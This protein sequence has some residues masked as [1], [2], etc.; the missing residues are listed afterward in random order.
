[1]TEKMEN[2]ISAR[3]Y[4]IVTASNTT[5]AQLAEIE[6]RL[7]ELRLAREI[8]GNAEEMENKVAAVKQTEEVF[9][10]LQAS[11]KLL[12]ELQRKVKEDAAFKAV[13]QDSSSRIIFG[14]VYSGVQMGTNNGSINLTFGAK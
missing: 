13:S 2:M 9:K 3:H 5:Q 6:K 14:T 10:V 11:Q 1:M 4:E 8:S 12:H 7:E